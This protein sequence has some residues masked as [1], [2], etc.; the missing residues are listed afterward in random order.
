MCRWTIVSIVVLSRVKYPSRC[1]NPTGDSLQSYGAACSM[2]VSYPTSPSDSITL[3]HTKYPGTNQ[4][5]AS[6]PDTA[7]SL[8]PAGSSPVTGSR[9]MCCIQHCRLAKYAVA[10]AGV[11][12]MR[13]LKKCLPHC[14]PSQSSKPDDMKPG[15]MTTGCLGLRPRSSAACPGLGPRQPRGMPLLSAEAFSAGRPFNRCMLELSHGGTACSTL[16]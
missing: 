13:C 7:L 10:I 12:H 1:S 3:P 16:S 14:S 5:T 11:P 8:I 9:R 4:S 15:T 6:R 2:L